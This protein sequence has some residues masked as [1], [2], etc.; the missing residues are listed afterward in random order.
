MAYIPTEW[1]TGDIVTAEKL[2]KLESGV[3]NAS[4]GGAGGFMLVSHTD[5][6]IN[7]SY[8]EL[9]AAVNNSIMP[10][11]VVTYE[12]GTDTDGETET[13]LY[14]LQSLV[15]ARSTEEGNNYQAKFRSAEN[16]VSTDADQPMNAGW[17]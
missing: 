10:V 8:N 5:S 16:F 9:L 6:G 7:K 17:N 4:G 2:N 1:Q 14:E 3:Q 15:S 13:C 11:V 12:D